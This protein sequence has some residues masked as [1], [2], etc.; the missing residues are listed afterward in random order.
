MLGQIYLD[1]NIVGNKINKIFSHTHT[2]F[3]PSLFCPE[4]IHNVSDCFNLCCSCPITQKRKY[5]V[6]Q[7]DVNLSP[8]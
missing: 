2:L 7:S 5:D 4:E 1:I 3:V 8:H 6:S